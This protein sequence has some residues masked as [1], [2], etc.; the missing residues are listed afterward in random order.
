MALEIPQTA[1]LSNPYWLNETPSLG[2]YQVADQSLIGL[3]ESLPAVSA[4]VLV[5]IDGTPISFD[6]P[7]V[8]LY[9]KPYKG[10]LW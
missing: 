5:N 1:P 6:I 10:E 3:P 7:L 9:A 8:Y 2:L 4:S